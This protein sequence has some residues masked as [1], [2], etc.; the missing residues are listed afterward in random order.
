MQVFQQ[1]EAHAKKM[2]DEYVSTEHI[3]LAL[4]ESQELARNC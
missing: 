1:A 4:A 2:T 3:L